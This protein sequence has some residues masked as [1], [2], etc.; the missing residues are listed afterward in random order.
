MNDFVI[1]VLSVSSYISAVLIIILG[2]LLVI[3]LLLYPI[4]YLVNTVLYKRIKGV[5]YFVQFI[6][7]K[8]QFIPWYK[9]T[10]PDVYKPKLKEGE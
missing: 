7:Y 10:R 2:S 1:N 3:S 8:K 5:T 9:E 4:W 6:R